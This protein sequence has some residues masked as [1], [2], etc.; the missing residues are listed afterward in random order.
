MTESDPSPPSEASHPDRN[1]RKLYGRRKGP[2]LSE[3]QA[4]LRRTLLGE[5]AYVPGGDPLQQFPNSVKEVW[6]EV[7]FGAGEHLVWQAK[8]H[9]QVGMIGAEPYEMGMAKLLTKLEETPLNTVRL[10]EG[11]GR[12][13]IEA[14]PDASLGRFFLLFPDPWPKT[15]HHKRRFLQMEMLDLLAAKLKPGAE[16]RFATDDKS[17]LPYALERLMAHPAF[18]WTAEGPADW[19]TRPAD[20]PPTRYEAK[21]I[22]GPPAFLRFVRLS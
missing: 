16:L 8:A 20:W 1:R 3:R 12:E 10:Y 13:I 21:A 5:L 4:G 15:R 18:A 11:D 14:L 19:R 17:Y 9:P 6:L 22:K 2:K 7:G